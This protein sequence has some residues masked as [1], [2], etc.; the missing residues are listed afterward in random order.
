[1]TA[2]STSPV[3][4]P[5]AAVLWDLDGTLIDTEPY[6]M[7]AEHDLVREFG[8]VWTEEDARS[9]IGF[10]LLDSAE[11]LRRRGG[12]RLE[13][14]EI[15]ERL[16][17]GVLARLGRRIPWRPGARRLLADL[18]DQGVPCALVTMS[19][20]PLVDAVVEALQPLRF[21]AIVT[22]DAVANG[23]PHPEPYLRAA[24]ALG[25]DAEDCVA[26]EDSPTGVASASAA[27]C[28]ILAVPN[29]VDIEPA[30]GRYLV[31]SLRDVTPTRLGELVAITPAPVRTRRVDGRAPSAGAQR[32]DGVRRR[33][34]TRLL[35][36]GVG[37]LVVLVVLAIVLLRRGDAA[38]EE[39]ATTT[40]VSPAPIDGDPAPING[41]PPPI[42][43]GPPPTA[44]IDVHVWAPYWALDE[45][46]PALEANA[47]LLSEVSPLW[48]N[49]TGVDTIEVD[50]GASTREASEFIEA[51]RQKGLPVVPSIFDRTEAGVMAAI[52]DDPAQRAQ[53][54]ET[55]MRFVE[56]G[57]YDGIDLDY[58]QFAFADDPATCDAT[59][60]SWV[61]F[62]TELSERLHA[63]GKT[64]TVSIPPVYDDERSGGS[65]YWVYDYAAITPLVDTI[66]VM[67]YDY[68]NAETEAG[69]V[70]PL[71]WVDRVIA[72]TSEA[73]GD[74][75]KLV[76]GVPLYCYNWVQ[77]TSGECPSSAEGTTNVNNLTIAALVA[78]SGAVPP[79]DEAAGEWSFRY[80]LVVDDGDT[81]CTQS[82]QVHYVD[83]GWAELRMQRA[84][85]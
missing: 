59:R 12:V 79:Y 33:R 73:S 25:V 5:P 37:S 35:V 46:L 38:P 39:A 84:Y 44:V 18:N 27:G 24:A 72:G 66:R 85:D 74:P 13:P 16:H 19:W 1:M 23:K 14:T 11:V 9:I 63:D 83:A 52:L 31:S 28:V 43:A 21:D 26:I 49:V 77:A 53:H 45:A 71:D 64:L 34:S 20:R 57:G 48:F 55:V 29:I 50:D 15:V 60:P 69:A 81:S 10:D 54:V 17:A 56:G 67:A 7:E 70:A 68:S 58:E 4:A 82:C 42:E 51:A 65:G 36:L 78:R 6:W 2:T 3:A 62:V 61:A 30:H 8:D 41:D 80:D 40:A 75:S 76:L 47:G 22:G 32:I